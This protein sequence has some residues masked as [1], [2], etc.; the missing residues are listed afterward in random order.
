MGDSDITFYLSL[1][2]VLCIVGSGI[3]FGIAW[4]TRRRGLRITLGVLLLAVAAFCGILSLPAALIIAAAGVAILA[5][6]IKTP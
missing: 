6:A 3:A 1:L 2:A 4:R 5:L